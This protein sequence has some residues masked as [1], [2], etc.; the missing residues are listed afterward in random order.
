MHIRQ[1]FELAVTVSA[2]QILAKITIHVSNIWPPFY[3]LPPWRKKRSRGEWC[4]FSVCETAVWL[5]IQRQ[6]QEHPAA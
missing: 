5:Y 6:E 1:E 3:P 2:V 4:A